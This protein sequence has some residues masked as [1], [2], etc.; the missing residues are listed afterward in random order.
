MQLINIKKTNES[1]NQENENYTI[2]NESYIRMSTSNIVTLNV[3][4]DG[5]KNTNIYE[6]YIKNA[7]HYK[8]ELHH[9]ECKLHFK[10]II[11]N[12]AAEQIK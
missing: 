1:C 9:H 2:L 8:W 10:I 11:D 5:C 12:V 7:S 3:S 4:S 6:N